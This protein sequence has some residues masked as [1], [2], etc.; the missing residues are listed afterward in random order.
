MAAGLQQTADLGTQTVVAALP[1]PQHLAQT[2]FRVGVTVVGRSIKIAQSCGPGGIHRGLGLDVTDRIEQV[3]Q[4][5]TAQ[6]KQRQLL[7][8][9]GQRSCVICL[10]VCLKL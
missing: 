3:A 8:G 1:L 5:R 10:H 2:M 4:W 7:T 9:A 6:S